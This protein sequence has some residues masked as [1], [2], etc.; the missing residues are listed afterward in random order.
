MNIAIVGATGM[1]GSKILSEALS[2]GHV[3]TAISRHPENLPAELKGHANLRMAQAEVTDTAALTKLFQGQDAI[4]HSYA[5]PSDP[6]PRAAIMEA[7]E[8]GADLLKAIAGY[9]PTDPKAHDDHVKYRIDAQAAGTRSIIAAAKAA[10][11]RRILGVGGAGTLL[12]NGTPTMN[13]P[14]FPK[15]FE[16]GAK[17]T[18]V[19]KEELKAAGHHDPDLQWT[20]LCPPME[21]IPGQR[22][23]KFRLGLDDLL[24]AADGSSRISLEDYA[25]A[26]VDELE[27]PKHTGKR[28]TLAY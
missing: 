17:S 20:V 7:R 3:V 4:I 9:Q 11:V 23:G 1:I 26:M 8:N 28:F 12:V 10:S 25:V 14:T 2:R 15:A 21:I 19:V 27:Q 24:V 22:T 6:A 16:G 18:A 13:L 5:P